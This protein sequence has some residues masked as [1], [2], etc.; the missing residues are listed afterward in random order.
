MLIIGLLAPAVAAVVSVAAAGA[1]AAAALEAFS[2]STVPGIL[3][4]GATSA[5]AMNFL[6]V[7]TAKAEMPY[8]EGV[9]TITR[10]F[11]SLQSLSMTQCPATYAIV[12]ASKKC[13]PSLR[14]PLSPK[15]S[16]GTKG[17]GADGAR[18][19][20]I[21]QTNPLCVCEMLSSLCKTVSG[22]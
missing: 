12:E 8:M 4:G 17:N 7:L 9:P 21:A 19:D 13:T 11:L 14:F 5:T 1:A 15:P 16:T 3:V 18:D 10:C 20:A 6:L 2:S 22:D